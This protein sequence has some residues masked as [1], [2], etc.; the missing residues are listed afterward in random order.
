M[1]RPKI[2]FL[3]HLLPW[4]LEGGG[5]IKSYHTLRLLSERY[6]I[7]LLALI[8]RPEEQ[9]NVSYLEPFCVGGIQ[10]FLLR[11]T[12]LSNP[13]HALRSLL[14]R[15]SFIVT[16][17]YL[18]EFGRVGWDEALR[19]VYDIIHIDHLQ[20]AQ[21]VDFEFSS[22]TDTKTILDQHNVEHRIPKR[23]AETPGTNP[24][25]RWYANQEWQKLRDFELDA[26]RG[27]DKT[28]TVSDDDK[29]AFLQLAPDLTGK[30]ETVPIGV[31]TDYFAVA[32]RKPDA[33]A[34]LSIGTM[35]WPPNVDAMQWF[36]SEVLPL[37]RQTKPDTRLLVVGAKPTP[38]IIGLGE[39][40]PNIVVTGTVPDVRPYA[41]ECGVFIV[42]LRSGS[43]MRVKILNALSMGLPVV[44]TTV[45]AEGIA[46][47]HG[48][49]ILLADTPQAFA[50][51]VLSI[52]RDR[53]L[54]NYL[55]RNGRELM[56]QNYS[57]SAV[58]RQLHAVY[59]T[60]L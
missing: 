35:Y 23:L 55:G 60:V 59:D 4:P 39:R 57:W 6:D 37:I 45:G 51:A 40:D 43:G 22:Y 49:D 19:L 58:G 41:S 18:F 27:V 29:N 13:I 42:P 15:K 21:F 28:L 16:R 25:L 38:E 2:L 47:T 14:T 33:N 10:C 24:L 32:E 9:E 53:E 52:L 36:V 54:G 31:D 5:Q 3:A 34:L 44:S 30:I 50:D 11:R 1:P 12:L 20:M 26:M 17:D 56:E 48:K 46:V 8:R 7:T